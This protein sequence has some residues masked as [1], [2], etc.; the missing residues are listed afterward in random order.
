MPILRKRAS[1]I[2]KKA[3]SSAVHLGRR[4]GLDAAEAAGRLE[5]AGLR[6]VLLA[7]A[8]AARARQQRVEAAVEIDGERDV[9]AG[10]MRQREQRIGDA[11]ERRAAAARARSCRCRGRALADRRDHRRDVVA[12]ACG[13]QCGSRRRRNCH[14]RGVPLM[15]RAT[16]NGP[17]AHDFQ[18]QRD[19]RLAVARSSDRDDQSGA[20]CCDP[21]LHPGRRPAP[22]RRRR[23]ERQAAIAAERRC[24]SAAAT[25]HIDGGVRRAAGRGFAWR[26]A[27]EMS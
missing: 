15:K 13:S 5:F 23:R 22:A 16:R 21:V 26:S 9:G 2:A 27:A 14:W 11:V 19:D 24:R 12:P 8:L 10:E 18:R 4:L 17:A 6:A 7:L 1:F 25:R 3:S 20:A